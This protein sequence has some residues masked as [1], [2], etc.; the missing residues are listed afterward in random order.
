MSPILQR[1]HKHI[2]GWENSESFMYGMNG[3][4]RYLENGINL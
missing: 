4:L 2:L 3:L 1:I